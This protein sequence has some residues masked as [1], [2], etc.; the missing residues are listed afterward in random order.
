MQALVFHGIHQLAVE[1]VPEP[2]LA[3][4]EVLVQVAACGICGSDL[5]GYLG[6]SARRNRSIPLIMGHEFTGRVAALGPEATGD[7]AVGQRVVVQPQIYCGRCRAC[8]AGLS[9]ICPNMAI[10]GIERAGAFAE[11]VAVPANRLF[12]LPDGLS[13]RDGALV[14]TLAVEVHL[15]RQTAHPLLR[16]VVVLG[17]GAQ[18]LLAVQLARLAGASQIIATDMMPHRLRLAEQMGATTVLRADGDVVAGVMGLTAGWGAEFVVDAVGASATRRQGIAALAPGGTFGLVGLGP[19]E[20]PIDFGP[21]INRELTLRG[22]Y[23]YSDDDFVRAL[24]LIATGHIQ[25]RGMLDEAPLRE[26]ASCFEQ[27]MDPAAGLTKVV[28]HPS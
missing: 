28:L 25:V 24:E 6:H 1:D 18:G 19:G 26:G 7:I 8:R 12:P 4:G 11:R 22:S 5:H 16:T 13:D 23:C 20:T 2:V 17:A 21:V 10:L 3:P 27:L 14:E 15:F 9:N